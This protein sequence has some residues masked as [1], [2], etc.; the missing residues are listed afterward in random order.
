MKKQTLLEGSVRWRT[1]RRWVE[2][3]KRN[4]RSL[5]LASTH[6]IRGIFLASLVPLVED[7]LHH[8]SVARVRYSHWNPTISAL[9]Q[10]SVQDSLLLR[11]T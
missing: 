3:M 1:D 6:P 5:L 11:P 4:G 2:P 8:T 7:S 10:Y 9:G